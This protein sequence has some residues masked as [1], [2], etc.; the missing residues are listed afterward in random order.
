M[1]QM[2]DCS[3]WTDTFDVAFVERCRDELNIKAWAVQGV[4]PPPEYP[5]SKTRA[6][7]DILRQ[8]SGIAVVGYV[9]PFFGNGPDDC[10][11]RLA[12]F[13]GYESLLRDLYLDFEDVTSPL[14][15]TI[16]VQLLQSWLEDCD[17]Y[18]ARLGS[19]TGIYTGMGVWDEMGFSSNPNTS[20][21]DLNTRNSWWSNF[22]GKRELTPP[23]RGGWT[24]CVI[25]QFIGSTS[26]YG[27]N[28]FD[29]SVISD[30][31]WESLMVG[32][33]SA[34]YQAK[35]GAN[36]NNTL[37]SIYDHPA[38]EANLEGI[39]SSLLEATRGSS[40]QNAV[41]TVNGIKNVLQQHGYVAD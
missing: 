5:P 7:L 20:Y 23:N 31:Y 41:D 1:R 12:L 34:D 29:L 4:N 13:D 28:G 37:S 30:D 32:P 39:I 21:L 15:V 24:E 6:Q 27:V 35:F 36:G 40:D 26:I 16:K 22:N 3:N 19:R 11:P 2:L 9:Y 18:S 8:V 17:A 25:H 14:S 38:V 33:V 10:R